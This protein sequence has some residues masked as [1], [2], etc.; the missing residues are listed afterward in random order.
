MAL[1][2]SLVLITDWAVE[3]L[4]DVIEG[5]LSRVPAVAVQHR[6]PGLDDRRFLH[7]ARALATVCARYQAPLFINRRLDIARLV[8]AHLHLPASGV[9]VADARAHLPGR[10]ISVAV[11]TPAEAQAGADLALVSPVFAPGSKPDDQRPPL[12]VEGFRALAK[13]LDCPA[14]ALGGLTAER[15]LLLAGAAG[16]AVI[17]GVLHAP[18]PAEA[19]LQLQRGLLQ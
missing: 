19:A 5:V 8:D 9:A 3:N 6:H 1:P 17:S 16:V 10:W 4:L 11:H 7:E 12:G 18:Q 2:F 13:R 15:A 14:F